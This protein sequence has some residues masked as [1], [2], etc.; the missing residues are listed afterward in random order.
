MVALLPKIQKT[1]NGSA[2]FDRGVLVAVTLACGVALS[3]N[4]ADPDLWGHVQYGRDAW[5]HGLAMT[6]TYSYIVQG[7]PWV[8]H[9]IFAE[10]AL[11][12]GN[13]ILGP[14]GLMLIKVAL[15]MAVIT[16]M[17]RRARREKVGLLAA[18][19]VALMVA[20]CLATHW[21]MRPQLISYVSFA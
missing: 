5:E 4:V 3:L 19:G 10:L 6:T 20:V 21:T 12:A 18:S 1:F 2:W 8:N 11:A 7:Y 9:E 14:A 16:L 17:I 15:G 13:D